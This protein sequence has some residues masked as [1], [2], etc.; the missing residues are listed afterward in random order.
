MTDKQ[1][2]LS[3]LK[4]GGLGLPQTIPC[5][6]VIIQDFRIHS[7]EDHGDHVKLFAYSILVGY[8]RVPQ[9][10]LIGHASVDDCLVVLSVPRNYKNLTC[11]ERELHYLRGF[12]TAYVRSDGVDLGHSTRVLGISFLFRLF[13]LLNTPASRYVRVDYKSDP[14]SGTFGEQTFEFE[15]AYLRESRKF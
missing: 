14:E 6:E 7:V 13:G 8:D 11:E 9:V 10:T 12:A 5:S 3:S 15:A 2:T 4:T 1:V